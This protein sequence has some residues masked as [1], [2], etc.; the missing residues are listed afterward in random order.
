MFRSDAAN[1]KRVFM[2]FVTKQQQH[3]QQQQQQHHQQQQTDGPCDTYAV[4]PVDVWVFHWL[5]AL[6]K[7]IEPYSAV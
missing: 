5:S 4:Q 6:I 7:R 3:Q 1:P 2:I